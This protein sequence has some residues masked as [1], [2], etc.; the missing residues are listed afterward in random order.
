M[1]P[2]DPLQL[3]QHF[4]NDEEIIQKMVEV[5]DLKDEDVVLE[6]GF[7]QGSITRHL[8]KK[9]RVIAVEIDKTLTI[10]LSDV[11]VVHA[12]ALDLIKTRSFSVMVANPPFTMLEPLVK[13][14][15]PKKTCTRLVLVM[16]K[17]FAEILHSDRKLGML[18]RSVYAIEQVCD[19]SRSSFYPPPDTDCVVVKLVRRSEEDKTVFERVLTELACQQDKKIKNAL[20]K[21]YEGLLTKRQVQAKL[22]IVS[23]IVGKGVMTISEDKFDELC[24]ALKHIE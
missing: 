5:A 14:M 3:G 18:V 23:N 15:F 19:V 2:Q 9:C 12:N 20:E 6:P 22:E 17:S 8:A 24:D 4:L 13:R 21:F 1:I 7:G 16:S 10:D 11:E